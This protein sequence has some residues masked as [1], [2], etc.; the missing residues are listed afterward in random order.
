MSNTKYYIPN[1]MPVFGPER[2]GKKRK[3]FSTTVFFETTLTQTGNR[4]D[5]FCPLESS[6]GPTEPTESL[7]NKTVAECSSQVLT[8]TRPFFLE[9]QSLL[10]AFFEEFLS[11]F[12]ALFKEFL[13]LF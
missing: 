9:V 1:W 6:W 13:S 11:L 5:F 3:P 10:I 7:E 4:N 8:A 2:K 12:K